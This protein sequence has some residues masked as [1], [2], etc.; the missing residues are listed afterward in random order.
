[1]R[2]CPTVT[3]VLVLFFQLETGVVIPQEPAFLSGGSAVRYEEAK[4]VFHYVFPCKLPL[5]DT[6]QPSGGTTST[7]GM[8][9]ALCWPVFV[10]WFQTVDAKS[11]SMISVSGVLMVSD[12][13]V[14]FVPN[15]A[16]TNNLMPDAPPTG[17]SFQY[18]A[19]H[20]MAVLRTKEGA[21]GFTFRA[22]CIGCTL[23]T[24]PLDTNKAAQLEGEYRDLEESLTQFGTVSKRINELAAQIRLGI[25]PK[26]QPTLKDPP[27]AMGLYSDLNQ[28]FAELCPEPAKSCVHSYAKY[29]A[30]KSGNLTFECGDPPDC[31]AFCALTPGTVRELKAGLCTSKFLDS[32]SLVPDWSGVARKMDAAR[33]AKGPIDPKTFHLVSH[34]PGPPLDFMSKPTQPDNPCSVESTYATA[35]MYQMTS[36]GMAHVPPSVIAGNK[37]SGMT[38]QYPAVAKAAHIEGVVVLQATISKQGSIERL[39]VLSGPPLLLQAALDAVKTWQYRPYMLNGEPV[40]VEAQVTVNF[41]QGGK[42]SERSPENTPPN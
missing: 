25:T 41:T 5:G 40:E 34:P 28:R 17:I 2:W 29:Q 12:S 22:M 33:E 10:S 37:I 16:K 1:M 32:A 38:P 8:T 13:L 31:S 11:E 30:C 14:R 23:G 20:M 18:D 3:F 15:D 42:A 26:N 7:N 21:Y 24:G 9:S 19:G 4:G 36:V 35:M 39:Q 27:E 6:P